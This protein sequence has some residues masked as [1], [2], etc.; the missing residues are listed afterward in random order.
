MRSKNAAVPIALALG[1]F[2]A[3][4]AVAGAESPPVARASGGDVATLTYPSIVQVRVDRTERALERAT[5]KIE[6]GQ[7]TE[8]ATAMKVV[9]RQMSSAWRGAKYVIRTAPAP[10]AEE[11]RAVPRARK[12]GDAPVGPTYASPADTGMLVLGLQHEVASSMIQLVDGAHG[13]GLNALAT[14]LNLADDRRD[15]ALKYILSVE[16][17]AP[18]AAEDARVH[19]RASQEEDA[20]VPTFASLMPTIPP[21]LNDELQAIEGTT[22]DA[23]DLTAGGRRLLGAAETQVKATLGFVN[24]TWP[25]VPAE[26]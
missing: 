1:I 7:P 9:R 16:P 10:V 2:A 6:N 26:D 17:P 14:T 13:T 20:A 19:A 4:P 3:T 23:T 25:P 24:T 15:A 5:K 11:A 8:A 22:S 12:S 18:P 21:Q